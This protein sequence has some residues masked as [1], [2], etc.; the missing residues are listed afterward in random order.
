LLTRPDP[1]ATET[2][3]AKES[4]DDDVTIAD[5]LDDA[6]KGVD[7][8]FVATEWQEF[9]AISADTY[10]KLMSGTLFVDCMNSFSPDVM[11]AAGLTYVGV[12]R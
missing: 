2:S 10:A 6:L 3:E 9:K 5:S 1:V 4:L 7:A 11:R 12:G 8:V